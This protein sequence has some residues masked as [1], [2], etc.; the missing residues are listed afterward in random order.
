[1]NVRSTVIPDVLLLEPRVFRDERGF[2]FESYQEQRYR[3]VG[4]THRFVQDNHSRSTRGILRGLHAQLTHP[5]GK[6]VRAV[7][8]TI[9]DVAVDIRP[10]SPTYG[11]WVGEELSAENFKQLFVP[12]GFAHGFQVLSE[13]AEVV[14][15]ATDYYNAPDE[16]SLLW[17][18]PQ[19]AIAWPIATPLLS[20]K[21]QVGLTF[22]A[23]DARLRDM[24][25]VS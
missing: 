18:D 5:Q 12:P 25:G 2:F 17:N 1:M 10:A 7:Q 15:K 23:L 11:K 24:R 20:A 9:W 13:T 19:L 3:D 21:D 8:G 6:L 16:V 22:A 14:Y 4:I